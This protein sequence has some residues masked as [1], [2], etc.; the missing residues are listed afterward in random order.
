MRRSGDDIR[1]E[2]D[3][4]HAEGP[5]RAR[6]VHERLSTETVGKSRGGKCRERRRDRECG[7]RCVANSVER[8]DRGGQRD[9]EGGDA[10]KRPRQPEG[11]R[12]PH[13]TAGVR[14]GPRRE[15]RLGQPERRDAGRTQQPEGAQQHAE[16]LA[17]SFVGDGWCHSGGMPSW[18]ARKRSR[19]DA[20][21]ASSR[22]TAGRTRTPRS[23]GPRRSE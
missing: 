19:K 18:L 10:T 13:R 8:P 9:A 1:R 4:E 2:R 14:H 12:R 20:A 6:E 21:V 7:G 5:E 16:D 15:P 17:L 3:T 23:F 11:E 22:Y